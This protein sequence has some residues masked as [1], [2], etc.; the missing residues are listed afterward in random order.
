MDTWSL[1]EKPKPY[2]GKKKAPSTNGADQTGSLP[3]EG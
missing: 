3:V 2:S 1:T